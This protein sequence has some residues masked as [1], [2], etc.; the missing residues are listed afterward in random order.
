MDNVGGS[1]SNRSLVLV[2]LSSLCA[3]GFVV[4]VMRVIGACVV[5]GSLAEC[6]SRH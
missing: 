3:R 2:A 5:G 1:R 4:S 6:C